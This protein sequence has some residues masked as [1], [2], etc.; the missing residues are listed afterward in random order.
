MTLE[1]LL[2]A[3]CVLL[4]SG[5]AA[6]SP[7]C[8]QNWSESGQRHGRLGVQPWDVQYA[9]ACGNRFDQARYVAGFQAGASERPAQPGS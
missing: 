1:H 4:S 2:A 5:C 6:L 8:A 3:S 7:D 9:A